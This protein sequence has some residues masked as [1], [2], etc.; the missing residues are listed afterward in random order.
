MFNGAPLAFAHH[1]C[2]DQNDGKDREIVDDPHARSEADRV[3]VLIEQSANNGIDRNSRA[4]I[5]LLQKARRLAHYDFVDVSGSH[6]GVGH[7]GRIDI[8]L[9][10]WTAIC[11]KIKLKARWYFQNEGICPLI[12]QAIDVGAIDFAGRLKIRRLQSV[13]Y[14]A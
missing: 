7:S 14:S 8:N 1:R 13:L 5:A 11:Q 4:G 9:Y 3:K 12:Q 6:S 2:A 10:R